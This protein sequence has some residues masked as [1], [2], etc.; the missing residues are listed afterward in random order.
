MLEKLAD[1]VGHDG[2]RWAPDDRVDQA[3]ALAAK[4]DGSWSYLLN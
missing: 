4:Q 3:M 1:Y 2:Q